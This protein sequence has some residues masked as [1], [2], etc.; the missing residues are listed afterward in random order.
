VITD[1]H[2]HAFPDHLAAKAIAALQAG[3]PREWHACSDGSV[4]GLLASMDAAGIGRS[5]IA[6]IA[7]APKQ[8]APIVGWSCGI[9]SERIVPFGSVHPASGDMRGDV[10]RIADAGLRGIKLHALYQGFSVD[11]RAVWPMYESIAEAGLILLFHAGRDI[12]FPLEDDRADPERILVAHNAFPSIPMVAAHSG[13]WHTWC[14]AV[15]VFSGTD[16]YIETSY[17]LGMGEDDA[18]R[19]VWETY[20]PDR[21]L[22]GTDSPW[23]DQREALGQVR[24]AFPDAE[25][26]ARVL[27]ANAEALLA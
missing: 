19:L 13:G 9:R 16:I 7:T 26:Q 6:S 10:M 12:A 25:A 18:V 11:D 27:C 14:Q 2:T 20:R 4:A 23:K 15:E 5:V 8:A 3:G 22:F 21:I 24:A 17:S 1:F